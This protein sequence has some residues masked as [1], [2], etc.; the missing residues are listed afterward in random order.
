MSA[1]SRDADFQRAFA[2]EFV[3]EG[4]DRRIT[5]QIDR[6]ASYALPFV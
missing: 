5:A 6:F 1:G 3:G 4:M 2:E